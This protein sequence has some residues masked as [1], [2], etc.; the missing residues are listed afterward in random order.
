MEGLEVIGGSVVIGAHAH[1]RDL[2]VTFRADSDG[3]PA[4]GTLT[5]DTLDNGKVVY[6]APGYEHGYYGHNWP[7]Q[8]PMTT[9]PLSI[10]GLHGT[11]NRIVSFG[12]PL[13][14]ESLDIA[15]PWLYDAVEL[16]GGLGSTITDSAIT[17]G[18]DSASS[19]VVDDAQA[20]ITHT[21]LTGAGDYAL[22]GKLPYTQVSMSCDVIEGNHGGLSIT[23]DGSVTTSDLDG[24]VNAAS[25]SASDY[26]LDVPTPGTAGSAAAFGNWWGQPDGPQAQQV[27]GPADTSASLPTPS[28]CAAD[29]PL[30]SRTA[31]TDLTATPGDA[32]IHLSWRIPTGLHIDHVIVRYAPGSAAPTTADAGTTIYTGEGDSTVVDGLVPGETYSFAV[33]TIN[34]DGETSGIAAISAPA[35]TPS[36]PPSFTAD[37]GFTSATLQWDQPQ[38]PATDVVVRIKQGDNPP[39]SPSDGTAVP[40]SGTTATSRGLALGADYAVSGFG[41]DDKGYVSNP[42]SIQL[43]GTTFTTDPASPAVVLAGGRT[44]LATTLTETSSGDPVGDVPLTFLE[45]TSKGT[46]IAFD[47][48]DPSDGS[49]SFPIYPTVNTD[50]YAY[51]KGQG[52]DLGAISQAITVLV[53]PRLQVVSLNSE[54]R[55]G[56]RAKLLGRM[57]PN[58]S[59]RKLRLQRWSS[60]GWTTIDHHRTLGHG[61]FAFNPRIRGHR[62]VRLR[63]TTPATADYL[64][65][66]STQLEIPVRAA[67]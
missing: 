14:L 5:S 3:H 57:T 45:H 42:V 2:D 54:I 25:D 12:A 51:F 6:F 10:N 46:D 4:T 64:H 33:F 16:V 21:R 24:N 18:G 15:A 53:R 59:H 8:H 48:I 7:T 31:V 36:P 55:S 60:S 19:V 30:P 32:D 40:V 41:I 1:L 62:T 28:P 13:H 44:E 67:N 17:G 20:T 35:G 23:T 49:M 29:A 38:D 26:D 56:Q 50:F 34:E 47:T 66:H 37:S 39:A 9:I 61:K 11:D 52:T 65:G 27:S 63:V 58:Q 22:L 43:H